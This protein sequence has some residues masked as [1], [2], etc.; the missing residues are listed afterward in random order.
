MNN[1][2]RRYIVEIIKDIDEDSDEITDV[3]VNE[4]SSIGG[5]SIVGFIAPLGLSGK[6]IEGPKVKERKKKKKQA[7]WK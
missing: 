3:D 5:G 7:T 6:D 2:L 1:V 4:F